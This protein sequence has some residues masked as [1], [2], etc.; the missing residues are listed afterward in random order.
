MSG[1]R[2][3]SSRVEEQDVAAEAVHDESATA[4]QND[5]RCQVRGQSILQHPTSV[6]SDMFS[7]ECVNL[8]FSSAAFIQNIYFINWKK[9]IDTLSRE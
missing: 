2:E 1:E 9:C 3:V 8:C 4:R 6:F 5:L 7:Q